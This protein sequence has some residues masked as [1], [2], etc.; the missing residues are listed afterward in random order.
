VRLEFA[1][2]KG[3][4]I[5]LHAKS[6]TF[7]AAKLKGFTVSGHTLEQIA[8]AGLGKWSVNVFCAGSCQNSSAVE[9]AVS[10]QRQ[11]VGSSNQAVVLV[12]SAA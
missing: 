11:F 9:T 6:P 10:C 7:R 1:K 8:V 3:A 5:I 2:I 4:K 12:C